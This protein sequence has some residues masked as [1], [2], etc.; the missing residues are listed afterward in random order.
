MFVRPQY[1][2]TYIKN[3][4]NPEYLLDIDYC[5]T[6]ELVEALKQGKSL[7]RV[8]DGELYI[9]NG[10]GIHYQSYSKTL[11]KKLLE[12]VTSYSVNSRYLLGLNKIP[13]SKSNTQL[14]KDNLLKCWLPM[15]VYWH[16]Y[17]NQKARYFDATAFYFNET[18]PKYF[19]AYFKTK[20]LILVT[21]QCNIKALQNNTALPF[22]NIEYIE[23]PA[24]DAFTAYDELK[25]AIVE[26]VNAYGVA[27]SLVLLACGPAS[28]VLALDLIPSQIVSIDVGRGIE[29][30]YTDD[31]IDHI[32]YPGM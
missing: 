26:K 13:I 16:L 25:T 1:L 11:Q 29:I 28:K 12:I 2:Y 20:Q 23:A 32:I 10:G 8:G 17:F 4:T 31:R 24:T 14:K 6:S 22:T 27:H 3:Y 30:A 5:N 19:E 9:M 7:I 18:I 21:N 15:K